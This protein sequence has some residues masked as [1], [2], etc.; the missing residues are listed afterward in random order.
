M[1]GTGRIRYSFVYGE[2]FDAEDRMARYVQ[3]LSSA[4]ADLRVVAPY[5]VR[6]RQRAGERL[7][8][9]RLLASHLREIV[10]LLDP[11][12]R[13][14]VPG[15]EEFLKTLPA[16]TVP[17]RAELRRSHRQAIRLV[18]KPMAAGR[19]P[20]EGSDGRLRRPTLRDDLKELRNQFF[21]YGHLQSG[22]D[23]LATAMGA[24][25]GDRTGYVIGPGRMRAEY[26]DAV[27]VR[28][29][30]PFDAQFAEE[31]HRRIVELIGPVS[32]YIHQVEA[33]WL[34][35]NAANVQLSV[36]GEARRGLS[37]VLGM[38]DAG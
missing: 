12:D 10:L 20:I 34:Y 29:A 22:D 27:A 23:A 4:L 31:M 33:A 9:V 13:R 37:E 32:T 25:R 5:A 38:D 19:P 8:F 36:P 6:R 14:V 1:A 26:A 28:L 30:H 21:H 2:V 24:A 15:V 35:R 11:P 18:E 17:A 3:R 7:D 16:D